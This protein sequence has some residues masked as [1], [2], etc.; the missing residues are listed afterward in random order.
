MADK[1]KDERE[2]EPAAE[3]NGVKSP[4]LD[5]EIENPD[6]EPVPSTSEV[7][8][9]ARPTNP[10]I[11]TE[12][13]ESSTELSPQTVTSDV[14]VPT[15]SEEF[16][17]HHELLQEQYENY[18][19]IAK[20]FMNTL[21]RPK[22]IEICE[23]L[24]EKVERLN[25]SQLLKVRRNNN[26]FFRYFLRVLKWTSE[27]QPLHLYQKWYKL[28]EDVDLAMEETAKWLG[29]KK[30]YMASKCFSDGTTIT[31]LAVS[32]N[33]EAGWQDAG[34]KILQRKLSCDRI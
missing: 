24:L 18:K 29:D 33:L 17:Q 6:I 7:A 27:N 22:D 15:T 1:I 32:N 34:L 30:S 12:V 14:V 23:D 2:N 21:R 28:D 25:A 20:G 19:R 10:E 3:T 11:E 16:Q 26:I 4:S 31:Y 9:E 13:R 5:D 8:E